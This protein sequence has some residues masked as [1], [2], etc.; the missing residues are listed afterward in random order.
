MY[1]VMFDLLTVQHVQSVIML[2][3]FKKVL[4]Q[5]LKCFFVQQDYHSPIRM[6][7]T[8]S[9]GCEPLTYLLH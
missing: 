3:E 1:A 8:K 5:E 9:Y 4:I 2:I 7:Y 6:N